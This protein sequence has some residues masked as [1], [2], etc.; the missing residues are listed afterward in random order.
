ML[1]VIMYF[2]KGAVFMRTSQRTVKCEVCGCDV[3]IAYD[4]CPRCRHFIGAHSGSRG[5]RSSF[6]VRKI[7]VLFVVAISG[8]VAFR[9]FQTNTTDAKYD[10]LFVNECEPVLAQTSYDAG[11]AEANVRYM[12]STGQSELGL[13]SA[14]ADIN[15]LCNVYLH[16]VER[17]PEFGYDKVV[18]VSLNGMLTVRLQSKFGEKSRS[19]YVD[20]AISMAQQAKSKL[21]RDG[22]L[23][24]SMSDMEKA[25]VYY[26]WVISNLE[27]K[28]TDGGGALRDVPL[29]DRISYTAYGG[30]MYGQA[31]YLGY[32]SMYNLFL[33]LENI[34]CVSVIGS[35]DRAITEALLDG[36]TFQIDVFYAD[37]SGDH[38]GYF[39]MG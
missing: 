12:L 32:V 26:D 18:C 38:E 1:Y 33:R 9:Y 3:P 10:Y 31:T 11:S 8:V 15:S 22:A 7:V 14:G 37:A 19:E 28:F 17:Y 21:Y 4:R 6:P 27:P 34:D 23:R 29:E 5:L 13:M 16:A 30:F 20:T 39:N 25:R 2:R 24:S 36:K 35:G